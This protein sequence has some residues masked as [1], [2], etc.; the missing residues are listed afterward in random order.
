MLLTCMR[1]GFQ[2]DSN[3]AD[4]HEDIGAWCPDCDAYVPFPGCTLPEDSSFK[5]LLEQNVQGYLK[6]KPKAGIKFAKR[7]S[8]L[9]LAFLDAG[10]CKHLILNDLDPA[11]YAFWHTVC[12]NSASLLSRLKDTP[13]PTAGAYRAAQKLVLNGCGE[14]TQLAWAFLLVNRL[15]FSGIP[16]S[17]P[18]AGGGAGMLARWNP[19]SLSSRIQ[20]I[21][22]YAAAGKIEVTCMDASALYIERCA[23]LSDCTVFVDPPY[24]EQGKHLYVHSFTDQQHK[25]LADAL[26]E[27]HIEFPGPDILVTYDDVPL[28]RKLYED[29]RIIPIQRNYS[30]CRRETA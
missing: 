2:F 8:P 15:S 14:E 23:W 21:S 9:R 6:D 11:V 26:L 12:T 20:K 30:I 22:E 5:V 25:D 1:C 29:V 10:L 19:S 24:V 13:S 4:C 28:V 17:C 27:C 18:M 3:D 16:M 7:L